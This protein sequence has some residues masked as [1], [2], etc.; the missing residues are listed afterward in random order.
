MNAELNP[1]FP[2]VFVSYGRRYPNIKI[3][4]NSIRR[5]VYS[6]IYFVTTESNKRLKILYFQAQYEFLY[7]AIVNYAD[8]HRLS[9]DSP[10][11]C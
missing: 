5:V 10:S 4:K 7:R 9:L 6:F 3:I 8:L 2:R 11:D 1:P